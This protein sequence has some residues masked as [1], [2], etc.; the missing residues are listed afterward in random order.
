MA[1]RPDD[2]RR[3]ERTQADGDDDAGSPQALAGPSQAAGR[4]HSVMRSDERKRGGEQTDE[5][6]E[7][8]VEGREAGEKHAQEQQRKAVEEHDVLPRRRCEA[9][10]ARQERREK[11][12]G[13]CRRMEK[14]RE[15]LVG[16]CQHVCNSGTGSPDLLARVV[17]RVKGKA[18][19]QM[20]RRDEGDGEKEVSFDDGQ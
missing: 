20:R 7:R 17:E 14:G 10:E 13:D 9:D 6:G 18:T 5:E 2:G 11:R 16:K 8:E 1:T 12:A 3:G 19:Q 4:G 15:S